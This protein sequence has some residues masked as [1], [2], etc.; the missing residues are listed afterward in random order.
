MDSIIILIASSLLL[1]SFHKDIIA[2]NLIVILKPT[3]KVAKSSN[4]GDY[5]RAHQKDGWSLGREWYEKY[6]KHIELE[7][8]Y[9]I[10]L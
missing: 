1:T 2:A 8:S 9:S 4:S 10:F 7:Y 3:T 5:I 6:I